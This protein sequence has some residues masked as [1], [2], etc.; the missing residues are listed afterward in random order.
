MYTHIDRDRDGCRPSAAADDAQHMRAQPEPTGVARSVPAVLLSLV[1]G[2]ALANPLVRIC[3][4]P[5]SAQRFTVSTDSDE[6]IFNSAKVN[7]IE[8]RVPAAQRLTMSTPLDHP[9]RL[10]CSLSVCR[11]RQI[12]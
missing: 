5:R 9:D 2:N 1:N 3:R 7:A 11:Y 8:R 12:H 10:G 6:V 4:P